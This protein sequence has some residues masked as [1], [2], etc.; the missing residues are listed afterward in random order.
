MSDGP[1]LAQK[2]PNQL[3]SLLAF[4]F[5]LPLTRFAFC[6]SFLLAEHTRGTRGPRRGLEAMRGVKGE[7]ERRCEEMECEL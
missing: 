6:T 3:N 1:D 7:V 5:F 4:F 2:A